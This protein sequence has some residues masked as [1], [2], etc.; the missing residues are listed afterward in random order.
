MATT[1]HLVVLRCGNSGAVSFGHFDGTS[2]EDGVRDMLTD[3]M[4]C[5]A[6]IDQQLD[7]SSFP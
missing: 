4:N 2:T 5:S 3:L 1:C 7:G 6:M